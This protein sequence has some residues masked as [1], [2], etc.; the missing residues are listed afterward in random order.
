MRRALTTAI[1]SLFAI[2]SL[3]GAALAG[4]VVV[5][6]K[7]A[8]RMSVT[9][10]GVTKYNWPVSTGVMG[11]TTPSG[12]YTPFRLE[13]DHFSVEWDDAPMPHSIFFTPK[14]HAIHGSFSTRGLGT[15][16]S[17]G[18]VR[19][20]PQNASILF[21]LVQQRGLGNTRIVIGDRT[22]VAAPPLL[23]N[24][25]KKDKMLPAYKRMQRFGFPGI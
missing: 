8:Q 22:A 25:K 18:C 16:A 9:V 4:I 3:A 13:E 19:L 7:S 11:Y 6:D 20:A 23:K 21:G 12:T 17:H 1:V 10:D 14:G 5:I 2:V 15:R 24:G